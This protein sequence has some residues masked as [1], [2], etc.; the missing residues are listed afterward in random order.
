MAVT[1]STAAR[2]LMADTVLG[3]L[4]V[5]GAGTLQFQ[6]SGSVA[7]ATLTLSNPAFQAS[8]NGVATANP[9]ANDTNAVGGVVAQFA[10]RNNAGTGVIFGSVTTPA[11]TGDI[12]LSSLTLSPGDVVVVTSL[13][14]ATTP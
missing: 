6:T 7:C 8:V 1:H 14:Y 9:I 4:N 5:G 10:L 12:K 11:G 13:L 3:L 2:N